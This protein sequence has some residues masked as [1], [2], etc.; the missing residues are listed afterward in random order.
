V[1]TLQ[2]KFAQREVVALMKIKNM[3]SN[4]LSWIELNEM[5]DFM[6]SARKID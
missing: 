3:P 6:N 2:I 5:K 1:Q 4:G